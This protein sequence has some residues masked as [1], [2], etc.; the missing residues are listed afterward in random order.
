MVSNNLP[1]Q[2][3]ALLGREVE[4]ELLIERAAAGDSRLIS[5]VGPPGSG[6]TRLALEVA[7]AFVGTERPNVSRPFRDGVYVVHLDETTPEQLPAEI[8]RVLGLK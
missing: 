7:S 3:T 1:A 4:T 6:K 5:V 8:A 2:A